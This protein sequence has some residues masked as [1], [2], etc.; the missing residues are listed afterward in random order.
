MPPALSAHGPVDLAPQVRP[1][2]SW[3]LAVAA[4][5]DRM[6]A[7]HRVALR[8]AVRAA[9]VRLTATRSLLPKKIHIDDGAVARRVRQ[10]VDGT[11]ALVGAH[12]QHGVHNVWWDADVQ[13]G[14]TFVARVGERSGASRRYRGSAWF[15]L[16]R[17][18]I[19]SGDPLVRFA[20]ETL[21]TA[22]FNAKTARAISLPRRR[23]SMRR[24]TRLTCAGRRCSPRRSRC[25][26]LSVRSLDS[27]AG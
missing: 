22:D 2:S 13:T 11:Q 24:P 4:V 20:L 15:H 7:A 9:G 12:E 14:L 26:R 10:T 18:L 16:R 6:R 25:T 23:G 3:P 17:R 1:P 5:G 19:G 8:R 27:R 21:S